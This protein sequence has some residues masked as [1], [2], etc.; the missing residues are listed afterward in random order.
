MKICMISADFPPATSGISFAVYNLARRLVLRG[1]K[2]TV[3]TRGN[4]DRNWEHEIVEGID[5]YRVRFWPLYPYHV[6]IHGLFIKALLNKLKLEFDVLHLHTPLVPYFKKIGPYIATQ[7]NTIISQ[8]NKRK[9]LD[10]YSFVFKTLKNQLISID[11]EIPKHASCVIAT[12]KG[13]ADELHRFYGIPATKI[14]VIPNGVDTD[15]FRPADIAGIKGSRILY[16]GR[17]DA[18]KGIE[19]IVACAKIVCAELPAAVF[20]IIGDGPLSRSMKQWV[21]DANLESNFQFVGWVN[22]QYL[23]EYYQQASVYL[24]PSYSEGMPLTLLEAMSCACPCVATDI[25]GNADVVLDGGTGFLVPPGNPKSL[26][27]AIVKLLTDEQLRKQMGT[28][29]RKRVLAEYDW[30]II[31]GMVEEVYRMNLK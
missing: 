9:I 10:F 25:V 2:V 12:S 8:I 11:Q 13:V 24:F 23:V 31:V 14:T 1:Y 3:I 16:T 28:N 21:Y 4:W 27:E 6:K 30:N 18:G 22:Q 20:V 26:A 15:L 5:L 29:A 19:D 17:L 7:H